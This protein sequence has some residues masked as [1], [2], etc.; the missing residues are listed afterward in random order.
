PP[1]Y[2]DDHQ[3]DSGSVRQPQIYRSELPW[4]SESREV[5]LPAFRPAVVQDMLSGLTRR[6]AEPYRPSHQVKK[7]S[8]IHTA[9]IFGD[10]IDVIVDIVE[11]GLGPAH[12]VGVP[13]G[14]VPED[15]Q[16]LPGKNPARGNPG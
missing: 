7:R 14:I 8:G 3:D 9:C 16:A 2:G 12:V 11:K 1:E 6:C 5:D 10:E 13:G 4:F 15:G